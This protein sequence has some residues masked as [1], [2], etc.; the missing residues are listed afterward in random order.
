MVRMFLR[1]LSEM[2]KETKEDIFCAG[3]SVCVQQGIPFE[4]WDTVCV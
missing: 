4:W 2:K 1:V 3:D